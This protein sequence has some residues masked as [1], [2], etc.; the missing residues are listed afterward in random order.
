MI[1]LHI[2]KFDVHNTYTY[3]L[4]LNIKIWNGLY[5][6]TPG[7]TNWYEGHEGFPLYRDVCRQFTTIT[8]GLLICLTPDPDPS[9]SINQSKYLQLSQSSKF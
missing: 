2:R 9:N 3:K 1:Y 6:L 8:V 5:P 4:S 7:S